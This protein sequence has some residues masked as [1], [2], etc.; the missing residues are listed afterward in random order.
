MKHRVST[1]IAAYFVVLSPGC[2][3]PESLIS[4]LESL[5]GL[6]IGSLEITFCSGTPHKF[7]DC[8]PSL[9]GDLW[10]D[11]FDGIPSILDSVDDLAKRLPLAV[12]PL[13]AGQEVQA[14]GRW[15][16]GRYLL[17]PYGR[18]KGLAEEVDFLC[19][20]EEEIVALLFPV[21]KDRLVTV[22]PNSWNISSAFASK[23]VTTAA[24]IVRGEAEASYKKELDA[25]MSGG[26]E[27]KLRQLIESR[28]SGISEGYYF[29]ISIDSP[30]TLI[31]R[32]ETGEMGSTGLLSCMRSVRR[33]SDG[34]LITGVAGFVIRKSQQDVQYIDTSDFLSAFEFAAR[35]SGL[36]KKL[37]VAAKLA[38]EWRERVHQQLE[39]DGATEMYGIR[40]IP[41]WIRTRRPS[42]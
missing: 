15:I 13:T 24:E 21:D 41:F 29:Q 6:R 23:A 18:V 25:V 36:K 14:L 7:D 26:F 32:I 12:P 35:A 28:V 11:M 38:A 10:D 2:V 42:T 30:A 37:K 31:Y 20:T 39:V 33:M 17:R 9:V 8:R 3:P 19:A 22:L 34:S 5:L 27:S 1:I 40:F 16:S 4:S